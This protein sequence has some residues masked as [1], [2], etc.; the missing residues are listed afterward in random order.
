MEYSAI[1]I[2]DGSTICSLRK[3]HARCYWL[4]AEGHLT[5]RLFARMLRK[6]APL[7]SAG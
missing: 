3:Y 5:R 1:T 7:P 6:I 4:L 2:R